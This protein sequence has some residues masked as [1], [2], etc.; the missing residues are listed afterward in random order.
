MKNFNYRIFVSEKE[1][2]LQDF[3]ALTGKSEDVVAMLAITGIKSKTME[4]N[5]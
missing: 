3:M 4:V 5:R 1:L 2:S